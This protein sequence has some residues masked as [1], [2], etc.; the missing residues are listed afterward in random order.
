MQYMARMRAAVVLTLLVWPCAAQFR[1]TAPLVIAP[2]LI[3]DSKGKF[4]D[5]LTEN[6]LLLYDNNVRQPIQLDWA[7]FPISLVVAVQSGK[8]AEAA[9]LKLEGSGILLTQ[10]VAADKGETAVISF[11]DEVRVR[12]DFTNNPDVVTR[13]LR[14]LGVEGD[15]ACE[16]DALWRALR[17]L[18]TRKR[19]RRRIIF[20]IAE[21]RDRKSVTKLPE[22]VKEIQR[23]NAAVYWLTFSPTMS[24]YT[25]KPQTVKSK[26]P[27]RNGDAIPYDPPPMNILNVFTELAHLNQPNLAELFSTATGGRTTDFLERKALE[28]EI[29]AIGDEVHRQY[30]LSFQPPRSDPGIFHEL[31]VEVKNRPQAVAKTRQGYWAIE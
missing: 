3:T 31:R 29:H 24:K 7:P 6:D 18:E 13:S 28:S 27:D 17:M 4:I 9:M 11:S 10:F 12:N 2:T 26:D 22:V 15:G 23:Q 8:E 21:K 14:G 5:G 1:T 30:I 25:E 19:D 16:L 20:M